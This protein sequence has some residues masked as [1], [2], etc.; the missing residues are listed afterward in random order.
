[1]TVVNDIVKSLNGTI[2]L[3]SKPGQGTTISI[4]L[5]VHGNAAAAPEETAAP[6]ED[7][8][9]RL[10]VV[11]DDDIILEVV[12]E[13]LDDAGH[14]VDSFKQGADAIEAIGRNAYDVIITDLGMPGVTGWDVARSAKMHE[15][16]LPVVVI[17][18]WG[19]QFT[20]DQLTDSGVDAMLAK[21][22]HLKMLRETIERLARGESA[23]TK[24]ITK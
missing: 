11:D 5:P 9:L 23:P 7:H 16:K 19:A 17:S 21:P 18:G 24:I 22:F 13:S 8:G 15:P 6:L 12:T 1:M 10:L 4:E 3:D 14:H 2:H 20:D